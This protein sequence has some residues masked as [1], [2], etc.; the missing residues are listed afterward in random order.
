MP[1]ERKTRC[2][3]DETP[4]LSPREV[5]GQRGQLVQSDISLHD[6]IRSHL[7]RMDSQNLETAVFVWE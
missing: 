3:L 2:T 7:G 4:Y 1:V 6:T 5:L